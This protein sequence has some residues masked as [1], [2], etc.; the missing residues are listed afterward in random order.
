MAEGTH[1]STFPPL[2]IVKDALLLTFPPLGIAKDAHLLTFP[3]LGTI[4][5]NIIY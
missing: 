5:W 1:L 2:G 3:P 4:Q